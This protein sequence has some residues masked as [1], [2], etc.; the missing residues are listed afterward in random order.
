MDMRDRPAPLRVRG[1]AVSGIVGRM[2]DEAANAAFARFA[3]ALNRARKGE[4]LRAAVT[5]DVQL[6]RHAP[7]ARGEDAPIA[8]AFAGIAAVER[9]FARTPAAVTF[10][11]VGAAWPDG[12]G[13][14]IEYAL[15]AGEFHNG[16][17]WRARLAGDGRIAALSHRPFALADPPG[18]AHEAAPHHHRADHDHDHAHAEGEDDPVG[19]AP[20]RR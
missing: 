18:L 15:D 14:A 12:D 19:S 11:T 8:E 1:G 10:R 7:G 5:E 6:D 20:P 13:W 9:W 17:I 2:P 3:A 4:A 16:G